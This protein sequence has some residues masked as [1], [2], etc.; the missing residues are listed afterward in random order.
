MIVSYGKDKFTLTNEEF[1][2][3]IQAINEGAKLVFVNRLNVYLTAS[4]IWAGDEPKN[5]DEMRLHDGT[6]A[7]RRF[8]SW[9]DK[10]SNAKLDANYYPEIAKDNL[11]IVE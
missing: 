3:F 9:H 5:S 10:F 8:G 7:V 1:N 2:N 4:F 6:I 11:S